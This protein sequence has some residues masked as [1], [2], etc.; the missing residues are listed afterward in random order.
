MNA[1]LFTSPFLALVWLMIR[2][3]SVPRFDLFLIGAALIIA[4]NIL[5]QLKPDEERDF[6]R[7]GKE[8]LRGSRLGFT[9]FILSIWTFGSIVY[10][11]DEIL[12]DSRLIWATDEYWTLM[13]LSATIFA[14]ILGF[15][16]ARLSTRL[17]HEDETML[18]LFRDCEYL[19]RAGVLDTN[20]LN[21]LKRLDTARPGELRDI[22]NT[23]RNGMRGAVR[24]AENTN[25]ALA[26]VE[27]QLDLVTHSKQQGRDI[28]ELL[29]LV[30]FAAVT[31][32][33]GL[34][35]RPSPLN[36]GGSW[37]GFLSEVFILLFVS[38]VAFLCVNLFDTRRERETPL[39][40]SIE[41]LDGD[42]R[43]F[44]RHKRNLAVQHITA[45]L[46]SIAMAST[47]CALLF[48]KWL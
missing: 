2:G 30:A 18:G 26:S 39:L 23:I 27:K 14:L 21:S 41:K 46:I 3:I 40:V 17:T 10:L 43:L 8:R 37:A 4:I 42:D 34:L 11:R 48:N 31:A 29:S 35:A 15:R 5:I 28:V 47:F 6:E 9:A 1:L 7:F 20:V 33:L 19:V 13:A 38:T 24:Q 25:L 22:Y 44:F 16:I 12:P 36:T 32:G 45:V